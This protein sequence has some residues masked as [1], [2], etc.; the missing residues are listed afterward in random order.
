[1]GKYILVGITYVDSAG[2]VTSRQQL[3][4]V[5]ESASQDGILIA[6]GGIHEGE[7]WNMPPMLR[8][9]RPAKPGEYVLEMSGET[10][11]DPDLLATWTVEQPTE[12]Q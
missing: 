5:I 8:A 4:G 10:I 1:M 3:H 9:I 12:G 11:Q 7:T 2:E 6:L